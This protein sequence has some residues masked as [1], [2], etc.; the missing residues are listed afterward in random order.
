MVMSIILHGILW[1][2]TSVAGQTIPQPVTQP[3][4]PTRSGNRVYRTAFHA[5]KRVWSDN[6]EANRNTDTVRQSC[7]RYGSSWSETRSV[8]Q[9]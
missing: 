7:L 9:L 2:E 3:G 4:T 6:Q 5:L 8:R 1:S